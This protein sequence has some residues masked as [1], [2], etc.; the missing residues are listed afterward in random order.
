M[1][2]FTYFLLLFIINV[3]DYDLCYKMLMFAVHQFCVYE[4]LLLNYYYYY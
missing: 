3:C 2:T 4:L 1:F